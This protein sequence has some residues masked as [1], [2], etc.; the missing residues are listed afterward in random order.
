M[1]SKGTLRLS[2]DLRGPRAWRLPV[3]EKRCE[4]ETGRTGNDATTRNLLRERAHATSPVV[5]FPRSEELANPQWHNN[6]HANAGLHGGKRICLP[7]MVLELPFTSTG[8]GEP[9]LFT[10]F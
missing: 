7:S 5:R 6:I 8:S 1:R 9:E 3:E 4:V 2:N 10:E